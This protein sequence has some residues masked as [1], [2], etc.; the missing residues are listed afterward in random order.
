MGLNV[1]SIT[2]SVLSRFVINLSLGWTDE[3]AGY[4]LVW[5]TFL[6]AA[7]AVIDNDHIGFESLVEAM[8]TKLQT[9]VNVVIRLLMIGCCTLL[10]FTGWKVAV[11]TWDNTVVSLPISKGFV[12]AVIPVSAMIMLFA[13]VIQ[14]FSTKTGIN[15]RKE[16]PK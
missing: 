6:G 2:L 15:T 9:G 4:S 10:T 11:L 8:P 5:I 3:I 7:W 1:I 16:V 12:M 13:L 14:L